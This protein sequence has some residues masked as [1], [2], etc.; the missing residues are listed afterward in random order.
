MSLAGGLCL[1]RAGKGVSLGLS[2]QEAALVA[3][4]THGDCLPGLYPD[5][6][7]EPEPTG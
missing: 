7:L 3:C 4:P 2:C 1:S 5:S 6:A